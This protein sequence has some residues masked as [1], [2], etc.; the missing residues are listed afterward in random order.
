MGEFLLMVAAVV[1]GLIVF[2]RI[3][4]GKWFWE[5]K[6]EIKNEYDIEG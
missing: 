2:G 3:W 4:T 6:K 5:E 1:A